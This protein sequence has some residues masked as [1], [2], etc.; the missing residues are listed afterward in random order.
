MKKHTNH[1]RTTR[2]G[3]HMS[4]FMVTEKAKEGVKEDGYLF[5]II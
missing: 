2:G 4:K 5:R 1:I 3:H